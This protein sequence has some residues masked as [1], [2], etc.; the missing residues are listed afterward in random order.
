[1]TRSILS[2]LLVVFVLGSCQKEHQVA[3]DTSFQTVQRAL[4][5]SLPFSVFLSLEFD[6]SSKSQYGD[7]ALIRIPFRGSSVAE[8]FVLLEVSEAGSIKKGRIINLDGDADAISYNGELK[9]WSLN[10]DLLVRAGIVNGFRISH[11]D[12]L[13]KQSS[14]IDPYKTLPEVIVI[15]SYSSD[16]I[17][18]S[19]WLSLMSFMSDDGG[20]GNDGW[21]SNAYPYAGGGGGTSTGLGSSNTGNQSNQQPKDDDVIKVGFETQ[22]D[23]PAVDLAKMLKCFD[24]IPDAGA[25]CKITI[26][27][28]VPVNSDPTKIMDWNTTSPG[29][30]WIRLEKQGA[31]NS[32]SVS[33]HIG[34]YPKSGAKTMLTDAPVAGKFVDNG[35]HEFNASYELTIPPASLKTAILRMLQYKNNM[36]DLD[37][38]NCTDWSLAVWNATVG[39][40]KSLQI[41]LFQMPGSM[42]PA[43]TSTPQGLYERI[44]ELNTAGVKGTTVPVVGWAGNSTGPC[45]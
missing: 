17:S 11:N 42:S 29:H 25:V 9:I 12:A 30:T 16:G 24:N 21:Y 32:G 13:T 7:T 10:G 43:G 34:F 4:K 35:L 38:Y 45:N 23:N 44:K 19:T 28:D 3:D 31:N 14:M 8:H 2:L 20:G 27:A 22:A 5:D 41:P 18:W 37:D 6:R 15:S 1:M 40:D 33:Q 26:H 39:P 36:Y